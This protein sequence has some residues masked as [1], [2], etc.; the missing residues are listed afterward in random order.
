MED[1]PRV[2]HLLLTLLKYPLLGVQIIGYVPLTIILQNETPSKIKSLPL[3]KSLHFR[4]LSIPV[5]SQLF[6]VIFFLLIFIVFMTTDQQTEKFHQFSQVST[7]III[8]TVM[9]LIA[10]VNAL[11]NRIN[12]FATFCWTVFFLLLP[13][14]TI[15]SVDLIIAKVFGESSNASVL[16]MVQ[17][18]DI[19]LLWGII[20]W[21]Y[22]TYSHT[23]FSNWITCFVKIYNLVLTCVI[24][25]VETMKSDQDFVTL[26]KI[27]E[28]TRAYDV[29]LE[30][31]DYFNDKLSVRLVSEVWISIVWILGSIYMSLVS[32][33]M[34]EFGTML[35]N[36]LAS[37]MAMRTL[38][39]YGNEGENLEQNRITLVKRLCNVKGNTLGQVGLEKV[40]Q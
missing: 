34:G 19:S 7:D 25:E 12:G 40:N 2:E 17:D 36:L 21:I 3:K 5:L 31:V 28:I 1:Q 29:I 39:T 22:F 24:K 8:I 33:K 38:Y 23:L 14:F 30:L 13:I 32:Y 37:G 9:T 6:L 10:L 16:K 15:L 26:D 18:P 4:W 20:F 35:T 11:G 27:D